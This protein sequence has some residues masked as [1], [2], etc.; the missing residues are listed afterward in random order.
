MIPRQKLTPIQRFVRDGLNSKLYSSVPAARVSEVIVFGGFKGASVAGWL[1][2]NPLA[3]VHTYEPVTEYADILSNRFSGKRVLVHRFGVGREGG[4]RTFRSMSD[5]T[6]EYPGKSSVRLD[7]G[8]TVEVAFKTAI[9]AARAWPA[10]I[11][12]A[13]VNIEGGE[14]ELLSALSEANLVSRIRDVFVQFHD[15]GADTP[16]LLEEARRILAQTHRLVWCYEMVWEYWTRLD[17]TS[18]EY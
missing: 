2:K 14:Y 7:E 18:G 12:V 3:T 4:S 9:E 1:G 13:E 16:T 11:D 10:K 15:I 5:A 17:P 6:S 8:A